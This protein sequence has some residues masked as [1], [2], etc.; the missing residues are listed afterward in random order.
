MNKHILA[1]L[2]CIAAGMLIV[3]LY[4]GPALKVTPA[5]GYGEDQ[6]AFLHKQLGA[7]G[8]GAIEQGRLTDLTNFDWDMVCVF[9]ARWIPP[10]SQGGQRSRLHPLFDPA[11]N[12]DNDYFH[13]LFGR[14]GNTIMTARIR[15]SAQFDYDWQG[16]SRLGCSG[17]NAAFSIRKETDVGGEKEI[18][19][20]QITDSG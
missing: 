19:I 4:N 1:F 14:A 18:R 20:F 15:R 3:K 17:S 12:E 10:D 7:V 2:F 8:D 16:K 5:A 13:L 9:G 6:A 11:F